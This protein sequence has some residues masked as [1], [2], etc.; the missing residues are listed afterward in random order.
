VLAAGLLAASYIGT[1]D[2]GARHQGH[3]GYCTAI[4]KD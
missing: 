1:D 4:G 3:N 2:T